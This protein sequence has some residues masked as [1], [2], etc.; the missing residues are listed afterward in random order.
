VPR[1]ADRQQA[2][3]VLVQTHEAACLRIEDRVEQA[4]QAARDARVRAEQAIDFREPDEQAQA[5]VDVR[6][7]KPVEIQVCRQQALEG[8]TRHAGHAR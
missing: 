8:M 2:D 1:R 7:E 5:C 3:F 6:Q 4:G